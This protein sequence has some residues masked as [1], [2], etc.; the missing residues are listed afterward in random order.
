MV[1]LFVIYLEAGNTA[2]HQILTILCLLLRRVSN[3]PLHGVG[4]LGQSKVSEGP[5]DWDFSCFH[6]FLYPNNIAT[7]SLVSFLR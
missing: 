3:P 1:A 6:I 7:R 4:L 2:D 5:F